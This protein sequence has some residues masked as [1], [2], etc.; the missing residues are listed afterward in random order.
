MSCYYKTNNRTQRKN[1]LMKKVILIRYGEIYLKGK[2]R[3]YF[4]N[5]LENNIKNA[6]KPFNVTLN[7]IPGRYEI[8]DIRDEDVDN[9]LSQINKIA[10]VYSYSVA[11][12]VDSD[13]SNI[14][15]VSGQLLCGYC[16]SIKVVTN[17][18]DKTFVKNS[19]EVSR[20]VGGYLLSKNKNL[21]VDVHNPS[22]ILNID[23]RENKKTY[24]FASNTT[25]IG[26]GGMPVSSS[27]RG[28]ILLSGGIDSPVA[29]YMM[30]KR[31]AKLYALHFHSYPYTSILAKEKVIELAK[32]L[33]DYNGGDIV[34]YMCS[35]TKVQE[36]IHKNCTPDY[37]ITLLRRAM[38]KV[39]ER[40]AKE[41]QYQ[42]I[43]TGESLGQVASQ[44]IES[45]TVV[46]NVVETIPVIRPLIAFDK[47]ETIELARKIN[48]FDI[49]IKP[50][51]DCCTVFL[52]DSPVTRPQLD[53]VLFEQSKIAFDKLVDEAYSSIEKVY[54][55]R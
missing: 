26:M 34:L 31:G 47:N 39:A 27:G 8:T 37:M 21:S 40:L 13:M 55:K 42:M 53:K 51:E 45:I 10:G 49:S 19:M 48:T 32:T 25:Y 9:I 12:E 14:E 30:N 24:I 41:K 54:I 29:F 17:R 36:A 50:Y 2:N 7:R 33:V 15:A 23:I 52:P 18:A 35:M 20:E 5:L 46:Q 6:L 44:T 11:V 4:E 43:I 3:K 16:G 28:L 22:L 38:F 1:E